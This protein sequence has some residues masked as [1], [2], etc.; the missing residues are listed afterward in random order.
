MDL[1]LLPAYSKAVLRHG[2][3]L[4]F[5]LVGTVGDVAT[6]FGDFPVPRWLWYALIAFGVLAAQFATYCDVRAELA[7]VRAQLG[8]LDTVEA[9]RSY[10]AQRIQE[11][12]ELS[13]EIG[14]MEL[15]DWWPES[16]RLFEDLAHWE[17]ETR[18]V[19]RQAWGRQEARHFDT[20]PETGAPDHYFRKDMPA[21]FQEYIQRRITRLEELSD[22]TR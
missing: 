10:L 18:A 20:H 2:W 12:R 19:I 13:D 16:A 14:A 11:A 9:K 15:A 6:V 1:R 5:A 8:E 22:A 4:L 21:T 7:T 17:T 3:W